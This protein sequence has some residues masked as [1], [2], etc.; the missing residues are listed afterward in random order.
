MYAVN[1][2]N[3]LQHD[4][5]TKILAVNVRVERLQAQL[6]TAKMELASLYQ[7]R[8]DDAALG[9]LEKDWKT[10]EQYVSAYVSAWNDDN[11]A[12]FHE[13]GT[14]LG[15]YNVDFFTESLVTGWAQRISAISFTS[16]SMRGATGPGNQSVIPH[17]FPSKEMCDIMQRAGVTLRLQF[18]FP[19]SNKCCGS[20]IF[21]SDPHVFGA[22]SSSSKRK[23]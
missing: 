7:G 3:G 1:S 19:G 17:P 15:W 18:I 9:I 11:S 5:Q 20:S 21:K 6:T 14:Q 8:A 23:K 10:L 16:G 22:T 12:V 4:W 2:A 13:A